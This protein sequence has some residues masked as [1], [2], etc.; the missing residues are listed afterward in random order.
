[1]PRAKEL[2]DEIGRA[3]QDSLEVQGAGSYRIIVTSVLRSR[4]DI[5][6]LRQVNSNASNES[7]HRYGTTFD[8]TYMRFDHYNNKYPYTIPDEKLKG[9]LAE[10]LLQLRKEKKCW[11]KYEIKQGCFHITVR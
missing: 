1:M 10:V 9:I 3:F 7:A 11:V 5:K 2:L 6:K 4:D 8:I